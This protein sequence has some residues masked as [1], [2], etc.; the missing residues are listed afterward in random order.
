MSN[1]PQTPDET[2]DTRPSSVAEKE[3]F[4]SGGK[5]HMIF[6]RGKW[7][8]AIDTAVL[9]LTGY[10]LMT[11]QYAR[12]WGQPYQSTLLLRTTG[13]RTGLKRTCGLPYFKVGEDLV[14]RGSN[15]G[16]PTDPHWVWNVRKN[17]D[18]RIR[19]RGRSRNVKAHVASGEERE[20]LF[21]ILCKKSPTTQTYQDGCAPRELP[22]VV[23]RDPKT[24]DA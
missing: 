18:A 1:S 11:K 23:L 24:S 14:V 20:R 19:I 10:S 15:G 12:A 6:L 5:R 9:W 2:Q 13:A 4:S 7:G 17:P 22:L 16:G 8:L 21:T 3:A